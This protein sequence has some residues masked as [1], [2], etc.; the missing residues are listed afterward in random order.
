MKRLDRRRTLIGM[1]TLVFGASG[2]VA[3]GAFTTGSEGSLGDNWIQV[4]GTDQAVS[5][6][7]AQQ[8]NIE[9]GSDG[10][11]GDSEESPD[12]SESTA[13]D[14]EDAQNAANEEAQQE[15]ETNNENAGDQPEE[16]P[17]ITTRVQVVTEPDNSGNTVNNNGLVTWD[18]TVA[19]STAVLGTEDGFF[20]GLR[21][22]NLNKQATTKIG[23]VTEDGYPDDLVAFIIANAGSSEANPGGTVVNLAVRLLN[24]DTVV[25]TDQLRFP[26]RVVNNSGNTTSRGTNLLNSEINLAVGEIIEV[27]VIFDTHA[28]TNDI[29]TIST[30]EFSATGVN[31]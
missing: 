10:D 29:E 27:V 18:G 5:F 24:D 9:D 20:R 7:S 22:Q 1:S 28:G 11:G 15:E 13:P 6:E 31:N 26:Y 25:E 14:D 3:S 2:F 23:I 16:N 30:I 4:A 12:S 8:V 17:P 19:D 21:D